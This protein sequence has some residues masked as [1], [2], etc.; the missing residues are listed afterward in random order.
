MR[1]VRGLVVTV[2]TYRQIATF[3]LA[4]LLTSMHVIEV[5]KLDSGFKKMAH[6]RVVGST[7]RSD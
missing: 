1:K 2:I 4:S 5:W 7:D 6:P 3:D